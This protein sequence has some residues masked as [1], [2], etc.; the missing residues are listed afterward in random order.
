M[1]K[2]IALL[3][4]LVM[5]FAFGACSSGNEE[6]TSDKGS[7]YYLNFKPEADAAWQ[8]LAKTYEEKTGVEVKVVTA[9]SGE[10][11]TTLSAQMGKDGAPT[12]F[13][14]GN[15]SAVDEW[16]DYCLDLTDADFVSELT[17]DQ[18]NLYNKDGALKSVGY[19][20]ETY[21]IIVNTA[22]LEEA[23]Y[24]LDDI[25]N[26]KTLKKA[27]E[28]IHARADELGFDA[29]T[30]SGLDGSSSWRFSG[31]LTSVALHYQFADDGVT[32]MPATITDAYMDNLR[33]IWDLYIN[34][35][36][37]DPAKLTTSTGD[38]A[39]AQFTNGEAVF[40]QNGTWEY[41]NLI[42][43]GMKAEDLAMM[44]IYIGVEGEENA[45]LC[46]GTENCWAVN[47]KASEKD[48][49]AT[50]DFINW[51]VTSEE[52]T[53]ML[54]DQF[55]S[56]PFKAAPES[57]NVFIA[58]GAELLAN[59]NYNISWAFNYTPNVESWRAGVVTALAAYS[60]DQTDANW[61]AVVSACVD[62]WAIEYAALNG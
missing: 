61:D 6:T 59:G 27:A 4:A 7:V 15:A 32:S 18:F 26:F 12:M 16:D 38:E 43:A 49:Q 58:D 1:K 30:A 41:S 10:Y 44:P 56:V 29:F 48:I 62:G 25:N 34:N 24:T 17:T 54:V 39:T 45:A 60:A 28:D 53:A 57:E 46:S 55:G 8:D 14:V 37:A 33:D 5:I 20:Y 35:T 51:V 23:G 52:G 22:L 21:G 40:Y 3:L 36:A 47:A 31:H 42:G 9:A 50:L 2:L 19:C 13:N 11:E